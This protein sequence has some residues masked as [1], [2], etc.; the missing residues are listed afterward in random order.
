SPTD[1]AGRAQT[2]LLLGPTAGPIV[3]RASRADDATVFTE[4]NVSSFISR[5]LVAQSGGGQSGPVGSVLPQPFVVEATNNGVPTPGIGI[6]WTIISGG[7]TLVSTTTVTDASGLAQTGLQL[8]TAPGPVTVFA[9][10]TDDGDVQASFVA[11]ALP[12]PAR[13][14]SPISG[15]GQIGETNGA[16]AAPLVVETRDFGVIAPGVGINW[17]VVS[18]DATLSG[19]TS[20]TDG[21]GRAQTGLLFGA[22]PGPIVVSATRADDS[23]VLTTFNVSS[24]LTRTIAIVGGDGQSGP[25]SG[26]LPSPLVVETRDNGVPVA[27]VDILWSIVSGDAVPTSPVSTTDAAGRAQTGIQFGAV[28]GPVVVRATRADNLS[29][30]ADFSVSSSLARTLVIVSGN[31]QSAATRTP[32]ANPL[33]IEARDNG[34]VAPGVGVSWSIVSGDATLV[35]PGSSTDTVGRAQSGLQ[36]GATAG[37]VV[38]RATRLDEPTATVDFTVA[39][40][41][42]RTLALVSGNAQNAPTRTSLPNPLIIEARDNGAAA[43]GIAINWAVVSGD[44]TLA[45]PTPTTDASGRAQTGLQVGA[46][47]GPIVVRA[48]RADNPAATVDFTLTATFNRSIAL[49]S[50][51]NQQGLPGLPLPNPIVI[52]V[53]GNGIPEPGVT[54]SIEVAGDATVAGDGE[55]SAK[56]LRVTDANGRVSAVVTLGPN[57]SGA[58]SIQASVPASPGVSTTVAAIANSLEDLPGLTGPERELGGVIQDACA[59]IARIPVAQRT[60]E[61]SD[62]LARCQSFAGANPGQIADA[63]EEL[64]PNTT[65][66]MVNVALQASQAQLDN[67]KARI[68]ALRSGTQ[69]SSFGGLA[70]ASPAGAIPVTGLVG[71]ALGANETPEAGAEFDRWGYFVSGT[72]GRGESEE[73][74]LTP[75]YDFDINGL[76]AGL[77]YRFSDGFVAGA[78]LG[79]TKQDTELAG[80]E[81]DV[82][83]DGYSL[84]AY[85]T[86]YRD[87][88]WYTDAVLT[89]GRNDYETLRRIRYTLT[90]PGG[91][92]TIDQTA[93]G[94]LD[95]DLLSIASTVGRDYQAG[96]WNIGPYGR[97][98]YSR[99][100][101]DSG[102]EL[103]SAG[104]GSGLALE[105]FPGTHTSLASVVGAKFSTA[106][107]RDWGI[108]MPHLQI[109]W[110]HEYRDDPQRVGARFLAD[111]N[112]TRFSIEGDPI[113]SSFFRIGGGLSVLFSGG[114]SGFVYVERVVGKSGFTQTNVALGIRG[115]F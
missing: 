39:S 78:S 16:L 59:A 97:V 31:G 28:A 22:T 76:T 98:L 37:T 67:L 99:I 13:S 81:G 41:L 49:I 107:S 80:G 101:F 106:L 17:S 50:G 38:V 115:E 19:S 87:E 91:T 93:R 85:A 96:T 111:P 84:S 5:S 65:L 89:W 21:A 104:P 103:I 57:S 23:T 24:S 40:T 48:T 20:P 71:K 77:D 58:V 35:A 112:A 36:M 54:V 102:R 7:G 75:N 62:L 92:S 51:G 94:Q 47:P 2:N 3:V 74:R 68:A 9:Q 86:F 45:A 14:I 6:V 113:D 10:R 32:L 110:E 18:G 44:A 88:S 11:N 4:F 90:G 29:V 43:P 34:V 95:G 114:R 25:T 42:A 33:V 12:I 52:E 55:T 61:Q 105:I 1:G 100:D 70:I 63:L 30:T 72:I 26:R 46:T 8:P 79:Y 69:G 109:E 73:G 53:R 64:L 83:A 27:G 56:V 108:L 66:A 15:D 82:E 60:P